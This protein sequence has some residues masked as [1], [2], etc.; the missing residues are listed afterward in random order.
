MPEII[1]SREANEDLRHWETHQ[2]KVMEKI[3]A[4]LANIA[5]TPFRGI[6][7]PEPLRH[8]YA[9]YWSRRIDQK[10]RL[11]YKVD[12]DGNINVVACRGHYEGK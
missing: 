4:L 8:H 10:N 5:Q 1:F 12:T 6:G 7:K 11:I 3:T 9:G 2:P